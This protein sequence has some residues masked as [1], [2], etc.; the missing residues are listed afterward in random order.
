MAFSKKYID[1]ALGTSLK[2]LNFKTTLELIE[3]QS[4]L[5][6]ST[7]PIIPQQVLEPKHDSL[8]SHNHLFRH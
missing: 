4:A 6:S 8:F 2:E 3:Y 5:V 1:M 7:V